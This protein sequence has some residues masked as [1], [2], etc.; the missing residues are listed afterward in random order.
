MT[1]NICHELGGSIIGYVTKKVLF[2]DWRTKRTTMESQLG[3]SKGTKKEE[4]DKG[5]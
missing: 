3:Y 2:N 4:K 1:V 5:E